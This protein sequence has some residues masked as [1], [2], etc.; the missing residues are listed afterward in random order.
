ML[1]NLYCKGLAFVGCALI[2]G[3]C[4]SNGGTQEAFFATLPADES[5]AAISTSEPPTVLPT[6]TSTA[7]ATPLPTQTDTPTAT[8]TLLPT[9]TP[10]ATATA[11]PERFVDH[12]NLNRPIAP[13]GVDEVDR[14]Y[15][16]G[17]TQGGRRE[18]HHGVEFVNPRGTP[19]LAAARGEVVFAGSDSQTLVGP[20]FNFY[21][22][23]VILEHRF[24]SPEGNIIYTVYAHIDRVDVEEG[25]ALE[26]GDRVG[27]VGDTGIAEGPHLHFEVRVGDPFEYGSTRNPDLWLFPKPQTGTLAGRIVDSNSDLVHGMTVQIRRP[28]DTPILYYGFSYADDTVNG[29]VS[30]N[31]NFTRG[32]LRA[33]DYEVFISNPNGRVLFRDIVTIESGKTTWVDIQ[34]P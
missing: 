33:A 5:L 28:V 17:D 6:R 34:F 20:Q 8:N 15:P 31:E 10:T 29:S 25:Q 7:T 16:Y 27:I 32:D 30:W 13:Q 26:Q 9:D 22:N 11:T 23:V 1:Y 12:Y 2:L 21:G 14:T 4:Q 3:A 19:V 18:T 24:P